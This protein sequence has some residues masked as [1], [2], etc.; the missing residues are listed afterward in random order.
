ME[1][2]KTVCTE[3]NVHELKLIGSLYSS[4]CVCVRVFAHI[5][6]YIPAP[7]RLVLMMLVLLLLLLLWYSSS[8]NFHF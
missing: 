4:T 6:A 7:V 8:H 1:K 3:I 2:K 5:V